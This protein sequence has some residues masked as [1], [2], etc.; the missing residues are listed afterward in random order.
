MPPSARHPFT[1][2][3]PDRQVAFIKRVVPDVKRVGIIYSPAEANSVSATAD[4]TVIS[5]IVS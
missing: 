3:I 5:P 1:F 4:S 2:D